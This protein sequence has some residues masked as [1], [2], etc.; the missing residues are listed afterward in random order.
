MRPRPILII[1]DDHRTCE[2]A[3]D[4]LQG[5]EFNILGVSDGPTA[6]ETARAL[7]PAVILLNMIAPGLD[8]ID[9][10]KHL[11]QDPILGD[12]PV[13]G[14]TASL[15]LPFIA[16]AFRAG[17]EFFLPKPFGAEN[18]LHMVKLAA[19][20]AHRLA[21]VP[22]H[23]RLPRFPIQI[24]IRYRVGEEP[25]PTREV[26]GQA[27]NVSLTGLLLLLPENLAP[28]TVFRLWLGLPGWALPVDGAVVWQNPQPVA[29]GRFRHGIHLVRFANDFEI[30]QYQAFAGR[31]AAGRVPGTPS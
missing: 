7:Q 30:V 27:G 14:I 9:T 11:K 17:A 4:F 22:I 20:T 26:A 10:C 24:P 6:F 5:T 31:V 1:D 21:R 28:G 29:G 15:D 12:I 25:H 23:Q 2:R 18:L 8:S 16:E 13:V 19:D 3:T